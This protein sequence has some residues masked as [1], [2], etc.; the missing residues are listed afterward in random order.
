MTLLSTS[1][2]SCEIANALRYKPDFDHRKLADAINYFFRLHLREIPIDRRILSHSA[3]IA[4]KANVSIYDAV[5]VALA[6][7]RSTR[8]VTADQETQY[9]RLKSK[10]YPLELL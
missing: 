5:P 4:Y 10:G 1:L 6:S 7:L 3:E 9:A 8:C 2:L